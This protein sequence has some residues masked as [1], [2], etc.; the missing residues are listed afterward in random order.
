MPICSNCNQYEL[1]KD[2]WF[3]RYCGDRRETCPSCGGN[4]NT[5]ECES[6][7]QPRYGPCTECG[8]LTPVPGKE[9][10]NCGYNDAEAMKSRSWKFLAGGIVLGFLGGFIIPG[11]LGT[12]GYLIGI[13]ILL[14]G[15]IVAGLGAF[16]LIFPTRTGPVGEV[17][18][19]NGE[20]DHMSKEYEKELTEEAIDAVGAA[21]SAGA[22][23]LDTYTEY[24]KDKQKR[25]EKKRKEQKRQKIEESRGKIEDAAQEARESHLSILWEMNCE[26][27]GAPQMTTQ[28]RHL[29]RNDEFD[30]IGFKIVNEREWNYIQ[31]RVQLQC[32][33]P[34]CNNTSEFTKDSLWD[35]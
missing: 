8:D 34:D 28:N 30:T 17:G 31:D 14:V 21:A 15:L 12:I 3:C 9:C 24:K 25:E 26:N 16:E 22:E 32:D 13:P 18:L 33:A 35:A 20:H 23:V 10:Q 4:L 1:T 27:C 6:C 2:D 19:S 11:L 5:E 29:I 7:G